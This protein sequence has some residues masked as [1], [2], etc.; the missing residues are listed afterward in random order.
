MELGGAL[1]CTKLQRV[2]SIAMQS[3]LMI[4]AKI[5]FI[6]KLYSQCVVSVVGKCP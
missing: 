2:L 4:Y 1:T 6:D 5:S 3:L